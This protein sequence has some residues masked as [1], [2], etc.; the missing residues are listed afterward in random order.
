ML[1]EIQAAYRD[2]TYAQDVVN[3]VK[4]N[5]YRVLRCWAFYEYDTSTGVPPPVYFQSWAGGVPTVNTGA[6]GLGLLDQV[7]SA[8]EYAGIKLILTLVKYVLPSS[9]SIFI[10]LTKR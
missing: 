4:G 7:V 8:A 9:A 10:A 1:N 6:N 5:D 2:A 3:A